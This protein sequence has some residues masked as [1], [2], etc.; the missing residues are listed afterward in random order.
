MKE[1]CIVVLA[2]IEIIEYRQ[3]VPR[4]VKLCNPLVKGIDQRLD[5][6]D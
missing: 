5:W 1:R 2:R 4:H 3:V 6:P